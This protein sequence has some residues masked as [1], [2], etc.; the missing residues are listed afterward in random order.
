MLSMFFSRRSAPIPLFIFSLPRADRKREF[1]DKNIHEEI[2]GANYGVVYTP[3]ESNY[4][5]NMDISEYEDEETPGVVT[6]CL[7][8]I[9]TRTADNFRVIEFSWD[10][11]DL[12]EMY[13]WNLYIIYN[14]LANITLRVKPGEPEPAPEA[15]KRQDFRLYL[16]LWAGASIPGYSFQATPGYEAGSGGGF[17]GEG[18]L[19]AEL[20]LFPFFG[21][22]LEALFAYDTFNAIKTI[23]RDDNWVAVMF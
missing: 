10:Y 8:L 11:H 13:Q 20:R 17:G 9:V 21:I 16:G 12:E 18:G 5:V 4:N 22:Q 19:V 14:A 6:N 23:P 15:P 2:K 1:F 7:T 3:E